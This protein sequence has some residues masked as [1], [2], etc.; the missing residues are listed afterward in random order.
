MNLFNLQVIPPL[1]QNQEIIP[2]ESTD[3]LSGIVTGFGN[4]LVPAYSWGITVI[5]STFVLGALMMILSALFK[6]GQWQKIGQNSMFW[7]FISLLLMRGLPILIL[8][9]QNSQDIDSL[10]SDFIITLSYSAIF[11]GVLSIAASLLFKFGYKLIEHPEFHRRSRTLVMVSIIMV[12]LSLVIPV[13]FPK[14]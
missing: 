6:N 7:S 13:I 12:C 10:L 3:F 14:I 1:Q 11:L 2:K 9:I 5:T 4:G 8:S